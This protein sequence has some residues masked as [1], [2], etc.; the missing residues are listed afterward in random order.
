MDR[1]RPA[2]IELCIES[3]LL[4]GFSA[5]Q[6]RRVAASLEQELGRLLSEPAS[7]FP[8]SAEMPRVHAGPIAHREGRTPEQTGAEIAR[9]VVKGWMR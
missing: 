2:E 1:R 4:E 5:E 9:S 7:A 8:R 3:L 6:G